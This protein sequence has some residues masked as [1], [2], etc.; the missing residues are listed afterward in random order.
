M[1]EIYSAF[2]E[3]L[4]RTVAVKV[5]AADLLD[6][7]TRSRVIVEARAAAA[8]DHPFICAV[9]DVLEHNG[10][11][12]IIMEWVQGETLQARISRGPL[13]LAELTRYSNEIAEAL[14]AAHARGIIHR[15]V[16]GANIMLTA[17]GHV[18]VMDFGLAVM[19]TA[20][21]QEETARRSEQKALTGTLPYVA[22]EVLRG[23][24]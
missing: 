19:T 18:K 15:D 16:K 9:H 22:P 24:R 14:G 11:P 8:L 10:Q 13:S 17:S 2:D 4:N 3:K 5:I 12:V 21:S 6:D 23:E 7:R 1:G 20:T